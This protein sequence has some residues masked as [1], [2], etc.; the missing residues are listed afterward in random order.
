MRGRRSHAQRLAFALSLLKDAALDRLIS[1]E[2]DFLQLP[3]ALPDVL[4]ADSRALC[5]RVRYGAT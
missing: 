3:A 2:S 4:G 1:G 5:H